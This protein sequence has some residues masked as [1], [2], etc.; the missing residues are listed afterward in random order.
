RDG[1]VT[2]RAV[3]AALAS[4]RLVR[5]ARGVYACAHLDPPS[6]T[7][8]GAGGLI[9]CVSALDRNGVWVGDVTG[10]HLRARPHHHL[11]PTTATFH[12]S[13][14]LGSGHLEVSPIDALL[15]AMSCLDPYNA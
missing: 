14:Q 1:G 9:D 3:A 5:A 6:L 2:R 4:G 13:E 15:Q 11:R 12:W 8:L 10:L 7:A